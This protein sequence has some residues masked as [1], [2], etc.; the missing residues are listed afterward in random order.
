MVYRWEGDDDA[1]H[2]IADFVAAALSCR[3]EIRLH[4]FGQRQGEDPVRDH[5]DKGKGPASEHPE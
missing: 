4:V 3:N 1:A 2:H 5:G